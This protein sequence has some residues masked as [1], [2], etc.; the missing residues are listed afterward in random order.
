MSYLAT[1]T[2]VKNYTC[3]LVAFKPVS[4]KGEE[5]DFHG[6]AYISF[7]GNAPSRALICGKKE[8]CIFYLAYTGPFDIIYQKK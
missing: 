2:P 8:P 6:P 3:G 7:S 1:R 5:T 4:D